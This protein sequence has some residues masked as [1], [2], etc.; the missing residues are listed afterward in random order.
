M[1]RDK[2]LR[3][4]VDLVRAMMWSVP[5]GT[6]RPLSWWARARSA[7]DAGA[8]RASSFGSM[9]SV[10]GRKLGVVV[11]TKKTAAELA[12][13]ELAVGDDFDVWRRYCAQEGLHVIAIARVEAQERKDAG[14]DMPVAQ[15]TGDTPET[16]EEET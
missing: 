10:M 14:A 2:K 4:A 13:I 5:R 16:E 9:V 15:E 12:R 11:P 6:I 8:K 7:L 3:L 1:D